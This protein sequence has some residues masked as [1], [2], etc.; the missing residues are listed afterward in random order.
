MRLVKYQGQ[1]KRKI[2]QQ[3]KRD[4]KEVRNINT[5]DRVTLR[6]FLRE[7]IEARSE[8]EAIPVRVILHTERIIQLHRTF[9]KMIEKPRKGIFK[10]RTQAEDSEIVFEGN[11]R[12]G[13]CTTQPQYT[14]LAADQTT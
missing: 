13:E 14:T 3:L 11:T 10:L 2:L 6:A 8:A 7:L 4:L 12:S 1:Q 5:A 9:N